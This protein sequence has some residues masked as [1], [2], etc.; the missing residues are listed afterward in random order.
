MRYLSRFR[1]SP[2]YSAAYRQGAPVLLYSNESL[3][4]PGQEGFYLSAL[5]SSEIAGTIAPPQRE[6]FRLLDQF[7][8][9]PVTDSSPSTVRVSEAS[10]TSYV[11]LASNG[12]VEMTSVSFDPTDAYTRSNDGETTSTPWSRA[13]R[14]K[15]GLFKK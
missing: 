2:T 3:F 7:L 8:V 10:L 9:I 4:E 12:S 1:P 5:P 14:C 13:N 6:Q 11:I 15:S